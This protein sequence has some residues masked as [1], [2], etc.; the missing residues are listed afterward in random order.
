M[1]GERHLSGLI[2]KQVI[3]LP[4]QF[5]ARE[6]PR[7]AGD[8]IVPAGRGVIVVGGVLDD[9]AVQVLLLERGF[10]DA[11]EP[12]PA[13]RRSGLDRSQQDVDRLVRMRRHADPLSAGEHFYDGSGSRISLPRA[14]RPLDDEMAAI[15]PPDG[16]DRSRHVIADCRAPA[17]KRPIAAQDAGD[18]GI[19][20][21]PAVANGFSIAGDG[22]AQHL[23]ADRAGRDQ[24]QRVRERTFDR[25]SPERDLECVLVEPYNLARRFKGLGDPRTIA[26]AKLE[27]LGRKP[28]RVDG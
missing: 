12:Q 24:R 21:L 17:E 4:I 18:R 28:E 9:R 27:I 14:R 26:E 10:L 16:I 6:Q 19:P 25:G 22:G 7:G 1:S 3:E 2:D 11:A 15:E 23:V 13:F 5:L 8:Q 20:L